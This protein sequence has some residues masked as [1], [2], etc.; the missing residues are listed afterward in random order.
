MGRRNDDDDDEPIRWD[1][2]TGY[3]H[4]PRSQHPAG[5]GRSR[6]FKTGEPLQSLSDYY[7]RFNDWLEYGILTGYCSLPSCSRHE[8]VP[9]SDEEYER[10]D[11]GEELCLHEV[12]LFPVGGGGQCRASRG[13]R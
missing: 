4:D 11:A 3:V 10:I 2:I 8:P 9:C 5:R 7:P 12:R 13:G 6:R 1:P